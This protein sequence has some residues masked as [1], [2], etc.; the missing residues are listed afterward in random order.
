M[1]QK[2]FRKKETRN[3]ILT[4]L[5]ILAIYRLGSTVPIP[6]ADITALQLLKS[7]SMLAMMN[8]FSGG[9]LEKMSVFA[10]GV[11][12]YITASI[13]VQLLSMDVIPSWSDWAKDGQKGRKKLEKA[14]RDMSLVLA[15]VEAFSLSY[16]FN[17]QYKI[18]PDS[19]ATTY[20]FT[21]FILTAGTMILTWLGD[22][23][24]DKGIGNG[25]SMI[26]FAGI[27][28]GLPAS[29]SQAWSTF[30][31]GTGKGFMFNGVMEFVIYIILYLAL[32]ILVVIVETA[33]RKIP[34]QYTRG[35]SVFGAQP[36]SFLP[37]KI[38]SA[39]VI[40]VIFA[41][42]VITAPQIIISFFNYKLYQKL[43][44][45]FSLTSWLGLAVYAALII[46]FSFFYTDM[47][48][49]AD[50]IAKNLRKSD[51]Y[52]PGIRAGEDTKVYLSKVIHR[53]TC[54]GS[55]LLMGIA[56]LPYLL[57]KF[58]PLTAFDALG[59][60]GIILIVGIAL[61]TIGQLRSMTESVDYHSTKLFTK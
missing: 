19:K 50:E 14:T 21:I 38:N 20:I 29:F 18:L 9:A 58:T 40:P 52:I 10:M 32:I 3:R 23:I 12:P 39:S 13:I 55:V 25:M 28:S 31:G 48:L 37:V 16:T 61:E 45:M 24:S 4:T 43:A 2:I 44:N 59:G 33:E 49:D 57:A 54:I 15:V 5:L 56:I 17:K 60:T 6:N 41:Q 27:V 22:Q 53:I 47:E 11:S 35:Q 42:S 36:S 51:A 34:I 1:I 8:L 26:I 30:T 46:L 7:N